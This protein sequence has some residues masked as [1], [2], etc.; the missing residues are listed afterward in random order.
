MPVPRLFA[1]GFAG[2]RADG[3]GAKLKRCEAT[4]PDTAWHGA[5]FLPGLG[6]GYIV[7]RD[8]LGARLLRGAR[9]NPPTQLYFPGRGAEKRFHAKGVATNGRRRQQKPGPRQAVPGKKSR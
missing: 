4:V 3:S 6:L 7:K 9:P 5:R 8:G 2:A 1:T